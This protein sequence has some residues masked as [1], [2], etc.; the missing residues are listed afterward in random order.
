MFN[1]VYKI[2]PSLSV[3]FVTTENENY[4]ATFN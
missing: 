4:V 1:G 3:V 2:I